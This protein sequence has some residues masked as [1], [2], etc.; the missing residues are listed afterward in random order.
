VRDAV[1]AADPDAKFSIE[2]NG[3]E[4]PTAKKIKAMMAKVRERFNPD[5]WLFDFYTPAAARMPKAMAAAVNYA[6]ANNEFLG[7]NAFGIDKHPKI[8]AGTDYLAVQDDDFHIDLKA[9]KALAKRTTVFFHLANS[10]AFAN[11][12]GCVWIEKYSSDNRTA[13][14]NRRARQQATYD[15][16]FAYPAFFPECQRKR[17]TPDPV[18]FAYNAVRDRPVF[19]AIGSLLDRYDGSGS[20]GTRE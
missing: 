6:H 19:D 8:P 12:V 15:F 13:Y 4:Y 18:V 20:P 9:V 11:S 7:G 14:I 1:I 5:G 10:P 3:L 2:L 16:R 17:S